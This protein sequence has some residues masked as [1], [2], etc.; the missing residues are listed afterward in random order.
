M[1]QLPLFEPDSAWHPPKLSELPDDWNVFK[2]VSIDTETYD[3]YLKKLGPSVRRGGYICGYSLAFE[4]GPICYVPMRHVCGDNVDPEQA[5]N[6]LKHHAERFTGVIVGANIPYDLD[7]LAE[8]GVEFKNVSWIRDIQIAEPLIDEHQLSYSLAAIASRYGL[9]GKD[10]S[11][12]AEAAHI[13]G[14]NPKDGIHALPGRFVGPYAEQDARLPLQILRKQERLIDEFD[15]QDIFDLESRLIPVLVKMRRK[16]VRIDER[17]LEEIELWTRDQEHIALEKVKHLTGVEIKAGD[18]WKKE[19]VAP[20]LEAIGVSL[21]RTKTGQYEIRKDI[22]DTIDHPVAEAILWSRKVNKLRTTFAAS[23]RE[24]MVN[25]RIHCTFT[26]IAVEDED[27][28]EKGARYGRMS[29]RDPNL[30]QQPSSEVFFKRWR[31]IYVP[32]TDLW[33][34]LD[35]SQ[36]E[37]RWLT[38][39]AEVCGCPGAEV[40][41]TKYREDPTTDNHQM[42][43]EITKLPREEAKI[44]YLGKCYGMGGAK[45][46]HDL[47][48]PTRWLII[49]QDKK[50]HPVR[51]YE[52]VRELCYTNYRDVLN[53]RIIEVAGEEGQRIIDEFDQ[54]APFVKRLAKIAQGRAERN[55]F[56][57]TA[58]GRRCHFPKKDNGGYDWTHK[59]LNR[60]IQG[61]SADQTKRAMVELDA[62]GYE[63]QLQVHDEI[64]TSVDS[65][66]QAKDMAVIM[67]DCMQANV[68]FKVD[69]EVGPSW[70]EIQKC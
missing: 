22:L 9:P 2:R 56:I 39:Y 7:F 44:I 6:Y 70:G 59:A 35:Y 51:A 63:L 29:C 40:A 16:G 42:M 61:S 25:G 41:A 36:Q 38:H 26:Q 3:P 50:G 23:I 17:K 11:L 33:A 8:E 10:E 37:P 12:L 47:N 13:Y 53:K 65:I 48:L 54:H 62:A 67:R 4:D 55:G 60:L 21:G 15:L 64:D 34:C 52:D 1:V 14:V 66:Q 5:I 24:Y 49:G 45:L 46:C 31:S 28:Q 69:V 30:Q 20:A 58:G 43:A 18:I 57:T 32:D 19:A 68:P 27:G